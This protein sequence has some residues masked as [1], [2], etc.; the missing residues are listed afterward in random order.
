MTLHEMIMTSMLPKPQKPMPADPPVFCVCS[1]IS[2]LLL[3]IL[4]G[5]DQFSVL[6]RNLHQLYQA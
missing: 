6:V 3:I 2:L 4:A 5:D 1:S